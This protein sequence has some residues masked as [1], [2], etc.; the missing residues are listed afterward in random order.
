MRLLYD[1]IFFLAI[2]NILIAN[3]YA[4]EKNG[5]SI[6]QSSRV[7]IKSNVADSDGEFSSAE[8]RLNVEKEY[9]ILDRLP[10]TTALS[11]RHIQINN[12]STIDLP[13]SLETKNIYTRFFIPMP[14]VD[15]DRYYL[16]I[17]LAPG[18]NTAS[19]HGFE[20]DAFRFNFGTSIIYRNKKKLMIV[21]GIMFRL[22]YDNSVIPFIGFKYK[23]NNRLDLNFLSLNPNISYKLNDKSRVL[24]ELNILANEFEITKGN[25][26]GQILRAYG[27]DAGIGYEHKISEDFTGKLS[28]G[29]TLDRR[30]EY[31]VNGHK[32][33]RI[34]PKNSIYIGYNLKKKF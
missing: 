4:L 2:M 29:S 7:A 13:S 18:Y 28:I 5:L 14:L 22:Q 17:D 25:R 10:L 23:V 30:F 27:F 19:G 11:I 24:F 15:D 33:D 12:T 8:Y 16:G 6:S 9:I 1:T 31:L 3:V 20:S 34:K 32:G 21:A 26:H